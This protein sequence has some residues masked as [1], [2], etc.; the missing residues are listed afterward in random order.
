[1]ILLGCGKREEAKQVAETAK[2]AAVD[3][4]ETVESKASDMTAKVVDKAGAVGDKAAGV[5]DAALDKAS[6]MS[7]TAF[8]TAASAY[9][10]G[11]RAKAELDK[12][13]KTTHDYDLAVDDVTAES[14][15]GKAHA[16]R[17]ATLP[18]VTVGGATVGYEEDVARSVGG[19]TRSKHFRA[20]WRR[21]DTIVRVSYF[22]S[23]RIDAIAFAQLLQKLVP[24]VERV[25]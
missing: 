14:P 19:V 16:K 8:D 25:L 15:E 17:L 22:T 5:K 9:V 6:E 18:T 21:G 3:T 7:G 13:Y 23:E 4:A 2:H 1:M 24:I 20:S 12:V 11:K 10:T